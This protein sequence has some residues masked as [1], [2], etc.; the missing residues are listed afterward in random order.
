MDIGVSTACLYPL[1]TEKALYEL[2]ERGVKNV[3]IFINSVDELEGSVLVE[4]RRIIGEYGINV[5]S[6]HPF[7]SPME[8]LFIF[9]DYPR[10]TEYLIDIYKRYFEVMAELGA[11]VFVLHGAMLSSKV[12]DERYMERYLRLYRTAR[13]YGVTVAQ[14]NICYCKSSSVKF[15]EE[16]LSQ[17]GDEVRFV[18]DLKQA[19]RSNVDPFRLLDIIGDKV[20]HL[21]VSDGD[22]SCDCLPIGKGSFDFNH[23]FRELEKI[24]YDNAMIVELYRENYNSYDELASCAGNMQKLYNK[25][26]MG[27]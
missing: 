18:V 14:E 12:P 25:Y 27:L 2:A 16:M 10:R 19:R 4:L 26:K 7:S 11:N 20:V 15:I 24:K 23:L 13:K 3:E 21:H 17:L 8:T 9:G 1:E 5:K 6:M 22:S